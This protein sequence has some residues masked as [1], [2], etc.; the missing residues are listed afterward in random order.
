MNEENKRHSVVY[1]YIEGQTLPQAYYVDSGYETLAGAKRRVKKL[2]NQS[3]LK[4]MKDL[5]ITDKQIESMEV[6]IYSLK[7][8]KKNGQCIKENDE[9]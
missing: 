4:T 7:E 5:D 1:R 8:G 3:I 2:K 6:K 9:D